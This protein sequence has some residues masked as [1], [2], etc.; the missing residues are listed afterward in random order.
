MSAA[1][2]TA[3]QARESV[4]PTRVRWAV[5][6]LLFVFY[7]INCVDRSALSV[8]LPFIGEDFHVSGTVQGII[9]SAFFWSYC[10]L[11]IPAA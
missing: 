2:E 3:P 1:V 11:Q 8:A 7:T 9:L 6:I 4:R 5:V 10:A